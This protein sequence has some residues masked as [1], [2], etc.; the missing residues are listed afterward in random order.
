MK[1]LACAVAL[2]SLALTGCSGSL[3]DEF[4]DSGKNLVEKVEACPSFDD[5][6]YEEPTEAEKQQCEDSL[7]ACTDSDKEKINKFMDCIND[8][9][10]CTAST[11]Q[12]F[13]ASFLACAAP[14]ETVSDKCLDT[15][16]EGAVRK[17]MAMKKGH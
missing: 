8:L 17:A 2:F 7:E 15:S 4:A 6:T 12:A 14:L 16:S 9:D 1:K 3:C 11:E 5:I 13:A 10:K